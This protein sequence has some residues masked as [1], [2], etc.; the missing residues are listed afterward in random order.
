MN[1][2][3]RTAAALESWLKADIIARFSHD[4][5]TSSG[6]DTWYVQ[7]H[8]SYGGDAS[9]EPDTKLALRRA[10]ISFG[11]DVAKTHELRLAEA[12]VDDHGPRVQIEF[13]RR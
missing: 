2:T 11:E 10:V 4:E 9:T 13:R 6:G 3:A 7:A 5:V 1:E 12:S 8:V